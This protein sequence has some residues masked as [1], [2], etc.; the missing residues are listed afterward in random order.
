[1]FPVIIGC[2]WLTVFVTG[3]MIGRSHMPF[4]FPFPFNVSVA[5]VVGRS[6]MPF[7]LFQLRIMF[8]IVM[9]LVK[10]CSRLHRSGRCLGG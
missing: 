8:T 3:I 10:D 2:D 6:H 4:L 5:A 9:W 1:M 7:F